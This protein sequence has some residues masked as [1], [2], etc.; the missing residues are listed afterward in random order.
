[1]ISRRACVAV[2][3]VAAGVSACGPETS[4][5][6]TERIDSC[7]ERLLERAAAFGGSEETVR[8]YA[9]D[10]YCSPFER[11]GWIYEDGALSIAAH[12]WLEE[13]GSCAAAAE[14]EPTRT[15]ACKD[16]RRGGARVLDCALLHHVRAGEVRDYLER[17][18]L[19]SAVQCDDGTPLDELGVR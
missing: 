5:S 1:M 2:A 15:V 14:G 17:L 9:R 10:T 13:G 12:V 6:A 4:T 16:E 8:R 11:N 18:R 7:V 3:V 19:E